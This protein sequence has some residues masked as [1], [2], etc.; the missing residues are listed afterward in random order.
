VHKQRFSSTDEFKHKKDKVKAT[1]G[2]DED[3]ICDACRYQEF[4]VVQIDWKQR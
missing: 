1:I 3:G 4:K 2:F